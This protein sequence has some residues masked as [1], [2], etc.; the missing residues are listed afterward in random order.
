MLIPLLAQAFCIFLAKRAVPADWKRAKLLPLYKKGAI[1]DP[2]NYHMIAV[3]GGF[4]HLCRLSYGYGL[5]SSQRVP[6]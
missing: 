3:S 1:I 4:Y 2:V 6:P 5:G